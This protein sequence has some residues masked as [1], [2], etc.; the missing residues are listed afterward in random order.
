MRIENH[1]LVGADALPVNFVPTNNHSGPFELPPDTIIIHY[2][3]MWD[4]ESVVR[5]FTNPNV[6]ASAHIVLGRDG[7]VF[8]MIPFNLIG[9]H[10]GKSGFTFPDGSRRTGFNKFSIGIE[11]DNAGLLKREGNTFKA[12]FGRTYPAHEVEEGVHRNQSVSKFWH[13]YTE[14]QIAVTEQI[15]SALVQTYRIKHILGHEEVAPDRKIDPGPAFPLDKL[16]QRL[17]GDDRIE[18]DD[19]GEPTHGV[20]TANRLNI[21]A[22]GQASA[23]KV[24]NPLPRNTPV[25]ILEKRNGWYRVSTGLTGWVFGEFIEEQE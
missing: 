1:R 12:W 17:L 2:T 14:K 4:A 7:A 23:P 3:A 16:R 21:R 13:S 20:V 9:W 25:Q 15:C 19:H 10:A 22:S 24:A 18:D 5:S 6:K 8:Q 11:I